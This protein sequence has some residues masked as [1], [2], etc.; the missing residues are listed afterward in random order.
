MWHYFL[1]MK[2]HHEFIG[3]QIGFD[4][5]IVIGPKPQIDIIPGDGSIATRYGCRAC[6]NLRVTIALNNLKL[7]LQSD[8]VQGVG[9]LAEPATNGRYQ[10]AF[11]QQATL[12]ITTS[13]CCLPDLLPETEDFSGGHE[14]AVEFV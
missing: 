5:K 12:G 6:N 1:G 7:A 13:P 9:T 11:A 8:V 10:A 2:L 3:G 14:G 4:Q